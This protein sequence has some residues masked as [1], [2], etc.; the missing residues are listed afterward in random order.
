[1]DY[2]NRLL[3][4]KCRL[5][6]RVV[7]GERQSVL[8]L[9]VFFATML[10]SVVPVAM[11]IAFII[12]GE[13][14][15]HGRQF[16]H[17]VLTCSYLLW[18][19]IPI[20]GYRINESFD[21][22]K[23]FIYPISN[24][25][26]YLANFLGSFL[27]VS[28]LLMM[29]T[30]VAIALV[31]GGSFG[32]IPPLFI[33]AVFLLHTISVGQFFLF[34]L[35]QVLRH[36]RFWDFI[37]VVVPISSLV[38]LWGSQALVIAVASENVHYDSPLDIP[39]S[40]L[41]S[42]FPPGVAAEALVAC[43]NGRIRDA[44][45][46]TFVLIALSISTVLLAS[47]LCSRML[48][49]E[50]DHWLTSSQDTVS[51]TKREYV[52]PFLKWLFPKSSRIPAV[53]A[54]EVKLITRE[55][56][57]R[58]VII[59]YLVMFFTITAACS[60]ADELEELTVVVQFLIASSIFFFGG[61]YFN[62]LSIERSGLRLA[63]TSPM[64][65]F[66]FLG[67]K[68]VGMW[69]I[70]LSCYTLAVTVSFLVLGGGVSLA[71]ADLIFGV[72]AMIVVAGFG[73]IVSV[74]C[75]IPL[76]TGGVALKKPVSFGRVFVMSLLTSAAITVCMFLLAPITTILSL[77]FLFEQHYLVARLSPLF[78]LYSVG[79]WGLATL[80]AAELF[81][82]KRESMLSEVLD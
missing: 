61:L 73:N 62:G 32:V 11:G 77:G 78:L 12:L 2:L 82:R 33:T 81:E 19:M 15:E 9:V 60:L 56:Q 75:P 68:N 46:W 17:V 51:Q 65:P 74:L 20:L 35:R 8:G 38:L 58:M 64:S 79:V 59:L 23:L 48:K 63:L 34:F 18:I 71:I 41:T 57:Y 7:M 14:P 27:D 42:L 43:R 69:V 70:T 44:F 49:G 16:V 30:F 47:S 67:A 10:F 24:T 53:A 72:T 3:W 45:Y 54:K 52:F 21:V 66:E 22:S 4:L 25:T 76:P 1:M 40:Q 37:M 31:H 36:R 26:L 5:N 13:T 6:G 55:P 39:F 50:F 80:V 29:P 28:S